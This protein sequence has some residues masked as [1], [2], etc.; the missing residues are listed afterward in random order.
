MERWSVGSLL[1]SLAFYTEKCCFILVW[2]AV[3][4][5]STKEQCVLCCC[6]ALLVKPWSWRVESQWLR[7]NTAGHV[8]RIRSWAT[9]SED[10]SRWRVFKCF[11]LFFDICSTPFYVIVE[12]ILA[13]K[14]PK[15]RWNFYPGNNKCLR[16]SCLNQRHITTKGTNIQCEGCHL[17]ESL[18]SACGNCVYMIS[19]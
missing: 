5:W 10:C 2:S 17:N 9:H 13:S 14:T 1:E 18:F 16:I 8:S 3:S 11:W 6:L 15:F 4:I 12:R 7:E 19:K